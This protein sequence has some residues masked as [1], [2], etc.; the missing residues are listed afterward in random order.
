[1]TYF[2]ENIDVDFSKGYP[3]VDH[4]HK[5][6]SVEHL[7]ASARLYDDWF[8]NPITPTDIMNFVLESQK[9]EQE[10]AENRRHWL[11]EEEKIAALWERACNPGGQAQNDRLAK[12]GKKPPRQL[13][14]L[15]LIHI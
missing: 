2:G 12:Q 15:S 7:M 14:R 11:S 13:I 3:E 1:M 8:K 6:S 5:T 4:K 9:K 10:M